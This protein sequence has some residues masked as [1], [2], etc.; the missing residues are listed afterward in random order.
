M[1]VLKSILISVL[2]FLI[3]LIIA[4]IGLVASG[5]LFGFGFHIANI[6]AWSVFI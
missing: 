2:F 3:C 4:A 1:N 6:A 5:F